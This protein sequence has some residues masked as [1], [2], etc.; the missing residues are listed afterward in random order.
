MSGKI[1]PKSFDFCPFQD[2]ETKKTK[3]CQITS[4]NEQKMSGKIGPKSFDF[5]P[6]QD[7]DSKTNE[8]LSNHKKELGSDARTHGRTDG[9][10][11]NSLFSTQPS[12]TRLYEAIN[13][14]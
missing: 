4:K 8:I 5:C 10:T 2:E 7:T 9:R 13:I 6:F 12:T 3:S 1:G 11:D 14:S